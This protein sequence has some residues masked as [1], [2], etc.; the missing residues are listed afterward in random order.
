[1][2][3]LFDGSHLGTHAFASIVKWCSPYDTNSQ[4]LIPTLRALIF[5][6]GQYHAVLL[7]KNTT[8]LR[9][10]C[11]ID[12]LKPLFN[13]RKIGTC[14]TYITTRTGIYTSLC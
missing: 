2:Q 9:T 12:E 6:N 11:F 1:M 14:I 4:R 13:L 8:K 3:T 10:Q 5:V 7:K